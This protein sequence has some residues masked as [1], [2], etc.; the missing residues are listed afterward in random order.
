MWRPTPFLPWNVQSLPPTTALFSSSAGLATASYS[1][2]PS[3]TEPLK[4]TSCQF[5]SSRTFVWQTSFTVSVQPIRAQCLDHV[6]DGCL[7]F[8][9]YL[10]VLG[11]DLSVI[12]PCTKVLFLQVLYTCYQWLFPWQQEAISPSCVNP[13][14]WSSTPLWTA[15]PSWSTPLSSINSSGWWGNSCIDIWILYVIALRLSLS[16]SLPLPQSTLKSFINHA[17]TRVF[18]S[19]H[20]ISTCCTPRAQSCIY[21][22]STPV[23]I[24]RITNDY[25]NGFSHRQRHSGDH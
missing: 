12:T 11:T 16:P 15:T 10:L 6:P 17:R 24:N 18:F 23:Q 21:P 3:T 4:W 13:S 2:P 19:E 9:R 7:S 22:C 8:D 25:M 14:W 5:G 1:S 20:P